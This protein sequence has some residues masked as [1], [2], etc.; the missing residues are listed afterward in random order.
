MRTTLWP[1]ILGLPVLLLAGCSTVKQ[2]SPA[3][4]ATEEMLISTAADRA[5]VKMTPHI[6]PNAKVFI[7]A[8]YFEGTDSKYAISAIRS[9]LLQ[10]DIPLVDDKKTADV[11]VEIRAGAL[12]TDENDMLIGIPSF[13]VPIPLSSSAVTTPELDLYKTQEQK[14]VAKFAAVVY[15]TKSQKLADKPHDP[16]YGFSHDI[17]HTVLFFIS[18]ETNDAV[19]DDEDD[20]LEHNLHLSSDSAS[21]NPS[22]STK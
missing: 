9:S 8:N 21:D 5:A 17:K 22:E 14:G 1:V 19:P 10:Q 6:P 15:D 3:R 11:V 13:N 20:S 7:D 12:S 2:S 4:T 16:Q 18:W